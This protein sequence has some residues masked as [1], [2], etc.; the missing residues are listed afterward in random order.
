LVLT[1]CFDSRKHGA[2]PELVTSYLGEYPQNVKIYKYILWHH[3]FENFL[4]FQRAIESL[5]P[6]TMTTGQ[7]TVEEKLNII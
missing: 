3:I 5:Q 1:G 6:V 4:I 2:P 7:T